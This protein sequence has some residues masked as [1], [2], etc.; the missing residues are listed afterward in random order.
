MK[1]LF[2]NATILDTSRTLKLAKHLLQYFKDYVE[3]DLKKDPVAP[4]DNNTFVPN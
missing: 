1:T 2:I 3:V 4:V